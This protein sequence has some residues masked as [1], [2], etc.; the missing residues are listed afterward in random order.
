[1]QAQE[2]TDDLVAAREDS[3]AGSAAAGLEESLWLCQIEDRRG[4]DW[5]REG[6]IEGFSLG[7]YIYT[8]CGQQ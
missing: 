4:V 8:L 2:R 7:N 1:V 5:L 3:L 6:M